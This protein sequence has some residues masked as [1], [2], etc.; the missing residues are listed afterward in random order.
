MRSDRLLVLA[1]FH[2][3]SLAPAIEEKPQ[4]QQVPRQALVLRG[5]PRGMVADTVFPGARRI[6]ICQA[7]D[8]AR[9]PAVKNA[10][11]AALLAFDLGAHLADECER[12]GLQGVARDQMRGFG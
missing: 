11:Q 12:G 7:G 1:V 10:Q 2:K 3:T 9:E 6:E 8:D 5:R 4:P